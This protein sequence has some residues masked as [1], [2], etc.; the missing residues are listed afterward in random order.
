MKATLKEGIE[1]T[2]RIIVDDERAISF[3]SSGETTPDSAAAA[4]RVYATPA[5]IKDIE[6]TCRDFLLEHLD[7]GE[8]SL[9]TAVDIQHL[10]PTLLGMWADVKVKIAG[11]NGKAVSFEVTVGDAVDEVV[12]RGRHDRYVIEV[13]KVKQ[14]LAD[15]AAKA[16]EAS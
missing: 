2:R 12:G 14:R 7:D 13:D 1:T 8:D 11:V 4:G 3:L 15:K 10:A 5:M 16:A 9:G 6:H